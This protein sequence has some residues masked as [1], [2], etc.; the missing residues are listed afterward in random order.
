MAA[1]QEKLAES[2]DVLKK[3]QDRGVSR[4]GPLISPAL[5]GSACSRTASC[6]KS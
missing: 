4:S 5:T 1:P 6:K 2:L 3:L